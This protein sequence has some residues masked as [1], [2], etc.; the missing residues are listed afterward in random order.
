MKIFL[1]SR[2]Q[3]VETRGYT[4]LS[5]ELKE[6]KYRLNALGA[7]EIQKQAKYTQCFRFVKELK[8]KE[9]I[10]QEK[11]KEDNPCSMRLK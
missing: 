1:R 4:I 10:I 2:E 5:P 8:I 9:K 11:Q 6:L 7:N 3:L